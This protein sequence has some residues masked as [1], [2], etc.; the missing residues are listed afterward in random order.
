VSKLLVD[1][2][3][4]SFGNNRVLSGV[5]F[6][7][8]TGEVAGVLGKN[9]CGKTT[10]F[11]SI[12]GLNKGD[13]GIVRFNNQYL[14]KRTRW[15]KIAYLP[16][17]NFIPYN[18]TVEKVIHLVLG[19]RPTK[20]FVLSDVRINQLKKQK[21]ETLS[22]GEK[23]YVEFLI[24]LA[25]ERPFV[26]LYEPFAEVEPIYVESML[27]QIRKMKKSTAFII[28][29]HNHWSV[30]K[31][32]SKLYVLVNGRIHEINNNEDDLRNYGYFPYAKK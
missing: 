25:F 15:K 7:I 22:G 3:S 20:E 5:Y 30:R 16:Q 2:V 24:I 32:C 14:E 17:E 4:V 12:L 29:D 6:K 31:I 13:F 26:L 18:L 10:F 23:R 21:V 9:G 8:E 19:K 28:T 1:S 11:R 27:N